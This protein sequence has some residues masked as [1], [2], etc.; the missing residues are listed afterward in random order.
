M[1]ALPG[2]SP[3]CFVHLF[4]IFVVIIGFKIGDL[5]GKFGFDDSYCDLP[6][7]CDV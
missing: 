1:I 2:Y 3:N 6:P 4:G 7:V 5:A